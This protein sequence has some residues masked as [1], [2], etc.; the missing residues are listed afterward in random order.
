MVG[1]SFIQS[2]AAAIVLG[3]TLGSIV[4][5]FFAVR[6]R[7]LVTLLRESNNDYKQRN[8]QLEAER[9]ELKVIVEQ[10][11]TDVAQLKREKTLPLENLTR[12][13]IEQN[14]KTQKSIMSLTAELKK[15]RTQQNDKTRR[16]SKQV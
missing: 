4:A 16:S 12:L 13:V 11:R 15:Q 9:D 8:E 3:S 10:L 5:G 1:N 6:Q 7:S 2:L 14:A